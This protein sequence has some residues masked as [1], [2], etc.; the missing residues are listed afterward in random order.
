[1]LNEGYLENNYEFI[2]KKTKTFAEKKTSSKNKL[3]DYTGTFADVYRVQLGGVKFLLKLR[4]TF[5]TNYITV[6]VKMRDF[7][8]SSVPGNAH[9]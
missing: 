3:I 9:L 2:F 8:K 5:A 7:I 1:M 6:N 4:P